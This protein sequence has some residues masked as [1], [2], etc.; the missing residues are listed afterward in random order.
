[1]A[2]GKVCSGKEAGRAQRG[3]ARHIQYLCQQSVLKFLPDAPQRV[4]PKAPQV[5]LREE[6]LQ[7]IKTHDHSNSVLQRHQRMKRGVQNSV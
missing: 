1:M 5:V 4:A 2:L 3:K 6:Q 7:E